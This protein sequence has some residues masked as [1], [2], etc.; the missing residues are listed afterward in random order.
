MYRKTWNAVVIGIAGIVGL[1]LTACQT[2]PGMGLDTQTPE[3]RE[4]AFQAQA[5]GAIIGCGGG[6]FLA[7]RVQTSKNKDVEKIFDV[8]ITSAG[9][10]AGT[11]VGTAVARGQLAKY[12]DIRLENDK[13]REMVENARATNQSLDNYNDKLASDLRDLRAQ[14]KSVIRARRLEA[15]RR[16]RDAAEVE[17]NRRAIADTLDTQQ[18]REYENTISGLEKEQ[19]QLERSVQQLRDLEDRAAV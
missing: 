19:A 16:Q 9:C 2:M 15:E 7:S 1:F 13:L 14:K 18:K 4:I 11:A 17:R 12:R 8:L 6:A 3:E 5:V 10:A